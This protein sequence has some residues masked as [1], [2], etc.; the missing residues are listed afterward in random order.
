MAATGRLSFDCTALDDWDSLLLVFLNRLRKECEKRKVEFDQA[1]LPDGV[2]RLLK[3]AAAVPERQGSQREQASAGALA[4]LGSA[5]IR[6]WAG[7]CELLAFIGE[8]A[9]AFLRLFTGQARFR[10]ADFLLIVQQCGAQALPIVSL[11]S[12]LVGMILAYVGAVQLKQFGAQIFVANL[13]G[14]GMAREMGAMM[15]AI[16]HGRPHRRRLR[17]TARHDDRR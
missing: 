16:H 9:L 1:G 8:A 5:A 12:F 3:L 11:I 17:R 15:T 4:R 6:L 14:L 2:Q 7:S 10:R 13:V